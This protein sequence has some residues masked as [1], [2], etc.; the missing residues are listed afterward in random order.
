MTHIPLFAGKALLGRIINSQG[1]PIDEKGP[2]AKSDVHTNQPV[3]IRTVDSQGVYETG[4][5]AIDLLAPIPRGGV[6]GIYGGMGVGKLALLEEMIFTFAQRSHGTTICLS[7]YEQSYA[8]TPFI[9]MVQE[10]H[11]QDQMVLIFEPA[12]EQ[13]TTLY[14]QLLQAGLTITEQLSTQGHEILLVIDT[15]FANQSETIHIDELRQFAREKDVLIIV[16]RGMTEDAIQEPD[17]FDSTI[18]LSDQLAKLSLWP[19]IDR[20]QTSSVLF[21]SNLMR[22]EHKQVVR[23][24]KQILRRHNELQSR[25]TTHFLPEDQQIVRRAQCI[26]FF[27]TQPFTIAEQF[28]GKPGEYLTVNQTVADFKAIITGQYDDVPPQAFHFIGQAEQARTK[29]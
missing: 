20:Q 5:K 18:V 2:I 8:T 3:M 24:V 21:E 4:I 17:H 16:L 9:E 12:Q 14:T 23:G 27:L 25:T 19:A 7:T 10:S 1:E 13:E 6:I 11:I 15:S 29:R 22:E 28:T 26:N